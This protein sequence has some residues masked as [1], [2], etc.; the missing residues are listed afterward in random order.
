MD[1][2]LHFLPELRANLNIGYDHSK[3]R[4]IVMSLTYAAWEFDPTN[5]GGVYNDLQQQKK[6]MSF[7]NS[8]QLCQEC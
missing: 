2:K 5:G 6:K 8:T 3:Q 7:L 4:G 1:Y